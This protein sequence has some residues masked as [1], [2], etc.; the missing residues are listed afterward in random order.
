MYGYSAVVSAHSSVAL[1]VGIASFL[2]L[3][4]SFQWSR[5]ARLCQG[6]AES[7]PVLSLLGWC[8]YHTQDFGAAASVC[9]LVVCFPLPVSAACCRN[10]TAPPHPLHP[11]AWAALRPAWPQLRPPR[12][13]RARPQH[14]PPVPGPGPLQGPSSRL[15]APA[16]RA[17]EQRESAAAAAGCRRTRLFQLLSLARLC[18]GPL[19]EEKPAGRSEPNRPICPNNERTAGRAARGGGAVREPDQRR[20]RGRGRA[21]AAGRAAHGTRPPTRCTHPSGG[22]PLQPST[23]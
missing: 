3:G 11:E 18:S 17:G 20:H 2:A 21:Q 14:V 7:R 8:Y 6:N 13:A 16:P 12:R 19:K 4:P 22:S 5:R 9:V 15:C 23:G 10:H 1:R